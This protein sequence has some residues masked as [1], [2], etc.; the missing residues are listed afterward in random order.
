MLESS[1]LPARRADPE[2][3]AVQPGL[4]GF[5]DALHLELSVGHF[6]CEQAGCEGD[7]I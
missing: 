1:R 6:C 3:P 2:D 5:L 4:H 7:D